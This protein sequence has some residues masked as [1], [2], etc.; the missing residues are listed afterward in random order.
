MTHQGGKPKVLFVLSDVVGPVR[1]GGIGTAYTALALELARAGQEVTILY[2]LGDHCEDASIEHWRREYQERGI[3]FEPLHSRQPL[4]AHVNRLAQRSYDVYEWIKGRHYDIVHFHEWQGN[5]YYPLMGKKLGLCLT[6]AKVCVGIHSPTLWNLEGNKRFVSRLEELE[7]DH[8][9]R[10]S[11]EWADLV[12]SASDYMIDY[13]TRRSWRLPKERIGGHYILPT[14]KEAA[15]FHPA[16]RPV[17]ELVFFGRLDVRKGLT[18][19]CDAVDALERQG[20]DDFTVTFLGKRA[21]VFGVDSEEYIRERARSW[22]VEWKMEYRF[23]DEAFAYLKEEGRMAVLPSLVDNMPLTV[24]ECVHLGLPFIAART[25]GIPESI[26]EEDREANLFEPTIKGLAEKIRG[27]LDQGVSMVRAMTPLAENR[28][29][30]V[31]WHETTIATTGSSTSTSGDDLPLISVCVTHFDRPG[32]LAQALDSLRK[33]TY[34]NIEVIVVDDGSPSVEAQRYLNELEPEFERRGWRVLRQ[35]N[36]FH[37]AARNN[38]ASIARGEYIMFMDDDNVAKPHEVELFVRAARFSGADIVTC[39]LDTF[40][41]E[42]PPE[43]EFDRVFRWPFLG[44]SPSV[45]L[46]KNCIGDTNALVRRTT[47]KQLGGF[48]EQYGV[49]HEDWEFYVKALLADCVVFTMPE[50]L[51]WYRRSEASQTR[52][53]SKH[54]DNHMRHILPYLEAV[55]PSLKNVILFAHGQLTPQISASPSASAPGTSST[56]S[57]LDHV[58]KV[59][60]YGAGSGG[61]KAL[62]LVGRFGWEVVMV[63]D[64]SQER[65]GERWHEYE[66]QPPENIVTGGVDLVIVSSTTGRLAI[67]R[68]LESI[69]L[70]RGKDFRYFLE[71]FTFEDHEVRIRL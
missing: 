38:A 36:R 20:Q 3:H 9:E 53:K 30:W 70:V 45:A 34:P 4:E 37:G 31:R 5:G 59:A 40:S 49:G 7:A 11:A 1:N 69:G 21:R 67:E 27:A 15:P 19:F 18:L 65:W 48:H 41:T 32:Y 66:I 22:R 29:A 60:I 28:A 26:Q 71:T 17:R 8:M 24:L 44:P 14:V 13:V 12:W 6:E 39:F 54:Y 16:P 64:G 2:A 33:Q 46:F 63:V 52:R 57:P 51:V 50:A 55:P 43:S 23:G 47:F 68:K 56:L 58:R 25:G 61:G 10:K 42:F 62:G 35:E